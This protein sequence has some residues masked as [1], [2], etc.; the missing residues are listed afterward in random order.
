MDR[1]AWRAAVCGVTESQTQLCN[2]HI[3]TFQPVSSLIAL[4]RQPVTFPRPHAGETRQAGP[5]AHVADTVALTRWSH[6][7]SL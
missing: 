3:H 5:G 2:L 6:A 4:D 7:S 1:E